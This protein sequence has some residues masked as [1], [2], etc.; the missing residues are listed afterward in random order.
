MGCNPT[1][2]SG[3]ALVCP[4][5]I[6]DALGGDCPLVGP[7]DLGSAPIS[8][9]LALAHGQLSLAYQSQED[10]PGSPSYAR[11]HCPVSWPQLSAD[12][13]HKQGCTSGTHPGCQSQ[14]AGGLT[15]SPMGLP[16]V[17][18]SG[19][20]PSGLRGGGEDIGQGQWQGGPLVSLELTKGHP[21]SPCPKG[22][23]SFTA[24]SLPGVLRT[25]YML[26]D[27]L[28]H[29]TEQGQQIYSHVFTPQHPSTADI[30][31]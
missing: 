8:M 15:Q 2:S 12:L 28:P 25:R 16:D 29:S 30:A 11:A 23:S 10:F 6:R 22:D 17:T 18:H 24:A 7:G 19:P 31:N 21:G 5:P 9:P 3:P 1:G 26:T 14:Q 13:Y 20:S 4:T 27:T